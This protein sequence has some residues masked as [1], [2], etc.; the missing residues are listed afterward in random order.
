M[1][2]LQKIYGLN[3]LFAVF[4]AIT[5]ISNPGDAQNTSNNILPALNSGVGIEKSKTVG[6]NI[7]AD[8]DTNLA[9]GFDSLMQQAEALAS[10][11][12]QAEFNNSSQLENLSLI[13]SLSR[14]GLVAPILNI[15]VGRSQWQSQPNLQNWSRQIARSAEL[16][17]YVTVPAIAKRLPLSNPAQPA[18][19]SSGF[20]KINRPIKRSV[21]QLIPGAFPSNYSR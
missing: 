17:G 15:S 21:N 1:Q 9:L 8:S 10:Q 5:L 18:V 6:L 13:V 11:T 20:F 12:I 19:Y 7:V 2:N 14:R 16:L 4:C 3:S